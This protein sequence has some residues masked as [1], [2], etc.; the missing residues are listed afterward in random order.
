MNKDKKGTCNIED[1][2]KMV[3]RKGK[4][5]KTEKRKKESI[6]GEKREGRKERDA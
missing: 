4:K 6:H 2:I 5:R 1:Q 3:K